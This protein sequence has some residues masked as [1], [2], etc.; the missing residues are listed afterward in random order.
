MAN[1]CTTVRT[2]LKHRLVLSCQTDVSKDR[3]YKQISIPGWY[4]GAG[5]HHNQK[6]LGSDLLI[7]WGEKSAYPPCVLLSGFPLGDPASSHSPKHGDQPTDYSL[8]KG[9]EWLCQASDRLDI[10]PGCIPMSHPMSTER[11]NVQHTR[12][13]QWISSVD[14]NAQINLHPLTG[15]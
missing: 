7:H 5:S 6:V 15:L 1:L 3:I 12:Y 9:C 10:C 13:L 4:G 14:A 11:L 2:C 8:P